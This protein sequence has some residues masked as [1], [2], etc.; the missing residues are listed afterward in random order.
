M[1]AAVRRNG[2]PQRKRK[3]SAICARSGAAV[4]LAR[5]L[6]RRAHRAERQ[7]RERIRHRVGEKRDGATEAEERAA[8]RRP[9]KQ[10]DRRRAPVCAPTAAGSWRARH[11]RAQCSGRRCAEED[12]ARPF[13]ERDE[14][15]LPE[16]RPG[17]AGSSSTRLAIASARTPS[18]AIIIRLRFQRSAAMPAGSAKSASGISR[19]NETMP[20][21]AGECVSASTSSGYAIVVSCEPVLERAGRSRAAR[22]R[23]CGAAERSSARRRPRRRQSRRRRRAA[24][25]VVRPAAGRPE[26]SR[27]RPGSC[28]RASPGR[29]RR[30]RRHESLDARV[31][32]ELGD[33]EAHR[34]ACALAGRASGPRS[35]PGGS[36]PLRRPARVA[37]LEPGQHD[38][39]LLAAETR[40]EVELA[41]RL[42]RARARRR[43]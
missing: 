31:R 29:A 1:N 36:H 19:A 23:G 25:C 21:F 8:E 39:E 40:R 42:R 6:E 38:R 5:L 2:W 10:D 41:H 9:G 16:R 14:R 4:D 20:A 22:S 3:P 28:R 35:R 15:D 7:D 27:S 37:S 17:A 33:A 18:A 43:G 32:R 30:R 12:G 26:P 24:A 11:D 34:D 13:D